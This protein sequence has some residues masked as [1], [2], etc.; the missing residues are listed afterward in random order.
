ML[1]LQIWDTV[2][3]RIIIRQARKA[4]D[5][6]LAHTSEGTLILKFSAIGAVLAFDITS[7]DSFNVLEQFLE[8]IRV[9]ASSNLVTILVGNKSDLEDR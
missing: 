8:E 7:K 2:I 9:S 6:L 3:L 1:K 5:Q 4:L